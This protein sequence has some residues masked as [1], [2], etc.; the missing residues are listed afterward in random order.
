MTDR[1]SQAM[2]VAFSAG[3][4]FTEVLY[5]AESADPFTRTVLSVFTIAGLYGYVVMNELPHN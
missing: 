5:A 1:A 3:A 4:L 2:A